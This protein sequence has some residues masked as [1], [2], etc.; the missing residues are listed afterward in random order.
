MQTQGLL[1]VH[2]ASRLKNSKHFQTE[3]MFHHLRGRTNNAGA[4]FEQKPT[5]DDSS[6][7]CSTVRSSL[8]LRCICIAKL[9]KPINNNIH[10][11]ICVCSNA[12]ISFRATKHTTYWCCLKRPYLPVEHRFLEERK[13]VQCVSV[14]CTPRCR[15]LQLPVQW[16]RSSKQNTCVV[17]RDENESG[18]RQRRRKASVSQ[19]KSLLKGSM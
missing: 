17:Q 3:T 4:T 11:F 1:L 13:T 6:Q 5:A 19:R 2:C 15:E 9:H 7:Q 12:Q 16:K 8:A 18:L 10:E 14:E